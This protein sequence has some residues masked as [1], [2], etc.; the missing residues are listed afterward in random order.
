MN[1]QHKSQPLIIRDPA[2]RRAFQRLDEALERETEIP[3]AEEIRQIYGRAPADKETPLAASRV[4][5]P[6]ESD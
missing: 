5:D 6:A 4:N 1:R 3:A 2:Y